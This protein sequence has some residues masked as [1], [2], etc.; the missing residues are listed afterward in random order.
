MPFIASL[1]KVYSV[2]PENGVP[3]VDFPIEM[4]F[5]REMTGKRKSVLSRILSDKQGNT[6]NTHRF[7]ASSFA[8]C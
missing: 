6:Y 4:E 1:P 3:L 7:Y 2:V 5:Y 8:R